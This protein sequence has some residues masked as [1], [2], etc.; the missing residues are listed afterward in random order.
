MDFTHFLPL[1]KMAAIFAAMIAGVRF[2]LGLDVSILVGCLLL[3]LLF[4]MSPGA[5]LTAAGTGL[6]SLKALLL[7]AIVGL[8]LVHVNALGRHG[9]SRALH[10]RHAHEAARAQAVPG[11]FPRAHRAAC[12]CPAARCSPRPWSRTCPRTWSVPPEHL[13]ALNYWY[14]HVWEFCWPLYPGIILAASLADMEVIRLLL[15][16]CPGSL[17]LLLT[18]W[19]FLL[20]ARGPVHCPGRARAEDA[21]KAARALAR[22]PRNKACRCITAIVGAIGLEA[23]MAVLL[24]GLPHELGILAALFA[25]ISGDACSRTAPRDSA[26]SRLGAQMAAGAPRPRGGRP[27]MCSR[28]SWARPGP[29]SSWPP[30]RAGPWPCSSRPRCC[31]FWRA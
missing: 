1:L 15:Y 22:G 21:A 12:P 24:P 25:A 30:W 9:P 8:I 27:C 17:I 11:L 3:G 28:R 13:A 26:C 14:R 29:S 2:R 23:A 20:Q 16:A 5:W 4:G 7:A 19:I 31:P 18:G 10:G 6:G